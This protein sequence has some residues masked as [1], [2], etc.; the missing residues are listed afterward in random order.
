MIWVFAVGKAFVQLIQAPRV[1]L[2]ILLVF[3]VY[4]SKFSIQRRRKEERRDE[5]LGEA[6]K[7][8]MKRPRCSRRSISLW[9]FRVSSSDFKIIIGFCRCS[10]GVRM[11]GI[12]SEILIVRVF[13]W[14]LRNEVSSSNR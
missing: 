5:E 12:G 13:H 9:P 8:P 7:R 10:V 11:P 3:R 6:V 14:I 4:G 2:E 1:T